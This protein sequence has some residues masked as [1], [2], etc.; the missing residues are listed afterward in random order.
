MWLQF[1]PA[2]LGCIWALIFFQRHREEWDWLEH[3][4]LLM[5]VSV[6]VAP[7]SWGLDQTVLLPALM[8]AL[9]RSPSRAVVAIFALMS[10]AISL[11]NFLGVPIGSVAFYVWTA[12]AW[13]AW[14]LVAAYGA[15]LGRGIEPSGFTGG[16]TSVS[17]K[18]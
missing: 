8:H 10:A 3:G 5:V 13:L 15:R 16:V 6:V 12:P 11:V 18:V 7:Y 9:Y 2:A 1:L 4:S 17:R 14:Y